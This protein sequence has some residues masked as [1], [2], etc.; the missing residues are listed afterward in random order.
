MGLTKAFPGKA[1]APRL[2]RRRTERRHIGGRRRALGTSLC[3]LALNLALVPAASQASAEAAK[4]TVPEAQDNLSLAWAVPNY[5]VGHQLLWLLSVAAHPPLPV[6]A[7]KAHFDAEFLAAVPPALLN[8]DLEALDLRAPLRVTS[9]DA[10]SPPSTSPAPVVTATGPGARPKAGPSETGPGTQVLAVGLRSGASGLSLLIGVDGQGLIG[11]LRVAPAP[12]LPTAPATWA[13]LDA[14]LRSLAPDVSF[15]VATLNTAAAGTAASCHVLNSLRPAAPRPL[16]SMFKLYVLATVA[17]EVRSGRLSWGQEV[18]LTASLQ[19]L[20]SGFLQVEPPGTRYSVSQLAQIMVPNSDNTAADRLSALVGRAAIEAQVAT[21]SA[22]ASLDSPF[23]RTR[24]LFVLKG[25]DYPHY[26]R[27]YLAMAASKRAGY[28]DNVV[29]R[30]PLSAIDGTALATGSP[31]DIGSL[32]WFASASDI[33]AEYAQLYADASSTA[34][35]PVSTALSYNDGGFALS[36]ST[37]PLVWFKGGS[38]QGVLTLGYLARRADGT[39]AIVVLELSD[40][41][42]AIASEVTLT[43][44]ADIRAAFGLVPPSQT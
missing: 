8:K 43:A 3:L 29:D 35:E 17:S 13:G 10:P 4:V 23:L 36:R 20:P 5:P 9:L 38:E 33:C 6:A 30:V 12:V 15:E 32:E 14:Q 1:V 19:S 26:A 41:T 28:L 27:A 18:A 34:L 21:T 16:A 39:V 2:D 44:L 31:R 24:E 37:W 42:K 11:T 25:A 7:L 22:H 40:P